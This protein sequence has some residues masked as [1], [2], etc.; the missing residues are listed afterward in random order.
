MVNPG[1]LFSEVLE[2][3]A[4]KVANLFIESADSSTQS[5]LI[6]LIN[7]IDTNSGAPGLL[8][9]DEEKSEWQEVLEAPVD[10]GSIDRQWF[11]SLFRQRIE[12]HQRY[13]N[14]LE[15][16]I[17]QTRQRY[18]HIQNSIFREPFRSSLL[19]RHTV[20]L[21]SYQQQLAAAKRNH[22]LNLNQLAH[23]ERK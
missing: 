13:R 15:K 7:R 5:E 23:F 10:W 16:A 18:Q 17:E 8:S 1:Q 20:A 21:A 9:G 4:L 19:H 2:Q 14:Y 6:Q 22:Q 11:I 12:R 3:Y